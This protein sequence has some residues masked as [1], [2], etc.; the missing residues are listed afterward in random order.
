MVRTLPARFFH[1]G[2]GEAIKI[3]CVA[4]KDLFEIFEKAASDQ[5]ILRVLPEIIRRCI[6]IKA[7]Y[8]EIDPEDKGE[9]RILDFGH[10]LGG[11]AERYYRFNDLRLT[12]GEA[13]AAG[14]YMITSASE[15]LG[16]TSG[17]Q[18]NGSS[19]SSSLSAFPPILTF[20]VIFLSPFWNME[21]CKR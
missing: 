10:T 17:V 7:H 18:R 12:H 3:G 14:M 13:T 20:P 19:T 15:I 4:D 8:V 21:K 5:D 6:T 1:N 9:R 2:L 11:A 16:L